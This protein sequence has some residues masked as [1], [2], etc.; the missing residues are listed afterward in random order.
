M[1]PRPSWKRRCFNILR[2][3]TN[4]VI[5]LSGVDYLSSAALKVF[6]ALA[7]R[8]SQNRRASAVCERR[9]SPRDWRWSSLGYWR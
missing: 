2:R 3:A 5:D 9:R 8:Q 1:R 6:E 7:D 4:V